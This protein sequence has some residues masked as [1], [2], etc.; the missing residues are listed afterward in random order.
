MRLPATLCALLVSSVS[1]DAVAGIGFFPLDVVSEQ[2]PAIHI[3]YSQTTLPPYDEPGVERRA[4]ARRTSIEGYLH[5]RVVGEIAGDIV[6]VMQLSDALVSD[7]DPE[8][9]H[10]RAFVE[11]PFLVHYDATGA[12]VDVEF[13]ATVP[14]QTRYVLQDIVGAL[15]VVAPPDDV[16]SWN[17]TQY[18]AGRQ[19]QVAYRVAA[20]SP[21]E[22]AVRL[23]RELLGQKKTYSGP[24]HEIRYE[25]R[26]S[27]GHVDWR[28]DGSGVAGVAFE[29]VVATEYR[30]QISQLVH[31]AVSA[32]STS[33]SLELPSTPEAAFDAIHG[34]RAQRLR[35]YQMSS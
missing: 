4:S 3:T 33:A 6:V 31:T 24:G 27:Q 14:W 9:T 22:G 21:V 35:F 11:A 26:S 8:V 18:I 19:Q 7:D 2:Q 28:A 23:E 17:A 25:V 10:Q 15:E 1:I 16:P 5:R 32:E 30:G 13:A 34:N 29:D 20:A 12:V